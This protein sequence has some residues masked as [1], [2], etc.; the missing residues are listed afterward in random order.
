MMPNRFWVVPL[1][2]AL[3]VPDAPVVEW[4]IVPASPTSQTSVT[5]VIGVP[6]LAPDRRLTLVPT[7]SEL[8]LTPSKWAATPAWPAAKKFVFAGPPVKYRA[9]AVGLNWADHVV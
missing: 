6:T 2:G 1:D 5:G 4:R 3:H 7:A 9:L 8:Q